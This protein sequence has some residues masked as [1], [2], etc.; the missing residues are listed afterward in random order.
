MQESRCA[1]WVRRLVAPVAAAAALAAAAPTPAVANEPSAAAAAMEAAGWHG[2]AIR[3]PR[4]TAVPQTASLRPAGPIRRGA[5]YGAAAGS[6]RVRAIQRML[7]RLGYR[8]GPVDGRFGR[9]TAAAVGW[10]RYKHSL[11]GKD[12]VDAGTLALLRLRA[13]G[14][15]PAPRPATDR[16]G[17][18]PVETGEPAPGRQPIPARPPRR[19]VSVRPPT[20]RGRSSVSSCCCCCLC[21][22]SWPRG[23]AGTA[24][25][26]ATP[27]R[28]RRPPC[29]RLPR[30]RRRRRRR[31]SAGRPGCS[32]TWPSTATNCPR[33]FP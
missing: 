9:R 3:D 27:C 10:F 30:G 13:G 8:P 32:A 4:R 2:R 19:A 1:P 5:G 12:T 33:G 17:V 7:R 28:F 18:L 16:E 15:K 29:L 25:P 20:S 21:S 6:A 26:A 24:A 23:S 11:A 31:L 22:C 14:A